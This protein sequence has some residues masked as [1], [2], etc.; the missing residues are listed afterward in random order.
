MNDFKVMQAEPANKRLLMGF[1]APN[2]GGKT[3]SALRVATGLASR[4]NNNIVL[5]D[6]ENRRSETY[7]SNFNFK[8]IDFKPPFNP[9]RYIEAIEA[10]ETCRPDVIIIDSMS[11]EHEGIGGVLEQ[12]E[13]FLEQKCGDDFRARERLKMTA[14]I[15]PKQERNK[16]LQKL[17]HT[18]THILLCFRAKQ[19]TKMLK[20]ANGKIEPVDMGYQLIGGE[21]FGY[22]MS[23]MAFLPPNCNGKPDWSNEGTRINDMDG[24]LKSFLYNVSQFNEHT[25]E[26]L[27]EFL[28]IKPDIDIARLKEMAADAAAMGRGSLEQRWKSLSKQEQAALK[29]FMKEY[30]ATADREDARQTQAIEQEQS[31]QRQEAKA[32]E[33]ANAP[34]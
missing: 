7:A 22:E 31:L 16:L 28:E 20:N 10:A 29:P 14:W 9:A 8:I 18:D 5:I 25:G 24:Q 12:H 23:I 3:V 13:S 27:Y 2:N 26:K 4:M 1:F 17:Q 32:R 11:H 19:K 30:G 15:K 34:A 21:E 6:T 33:A